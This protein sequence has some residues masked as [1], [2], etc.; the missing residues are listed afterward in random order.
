MNLQ[1]KLCCSF[2]P[3]FLSHVLFPELLPSLMLENVVETY[4]CTLLTLAISAGLRAP[5]ISCLFANIN[6]EAPDNLCQKQKQGEIVKH[7]QRN[8]RLQNIALAKYFTTVSGMRFYQQ[9]RKK[10]VQL[11]MWWLKKWNS[12]LLCCFNKWKTMSDFIS[13]CAVLQNKRSIDF[14]IH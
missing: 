8:Y 5:W 14:V 1:I 4:A 10:K 12:S 13:N 9:K 11:L 6:K 7:D 3:P 2:F